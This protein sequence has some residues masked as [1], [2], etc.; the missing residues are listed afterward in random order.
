MRGTE[1]RVIRAGGGGHADVPR[2][3]S[4]SEEA[5]EEAGERTQR[6]KQGVFHWHITLKVAL[7]SKYSRKEVGII[8]K[9]A[10]KA[11]E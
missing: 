3:S 5:S 4:A 6:T 8:L 10:F 1:N 9:T 7:H 2:L 11:S